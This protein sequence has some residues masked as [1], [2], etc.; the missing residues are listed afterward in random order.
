MK[1]DDTRRQSAIDKLNAYMESEMRRLIADGL[2]REYAEPG[3]YGA[4]IVNAIR[5]NPEYAAPFS[6]S[7]ASFLRSIGIDPQ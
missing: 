2:R 6:A 7:D 4:S 3:F 5:P 1:D